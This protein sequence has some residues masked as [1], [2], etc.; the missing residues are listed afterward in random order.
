MQRHRGQ[1]SISGVF[2]YHCPPYFL[3]Q[4]L[5]LSLELTSWLTAVPPVSPTPVNETMAVHH[6]AQFV[7]VGAGLQAFS[8]PSLHL[9]VEPLP[10]PFEGGIPLVLVSTPLQR[11]F[12]LSLHW[13][14]LEVRSADTEHVNI[15]VPPPTLSHC[16][17]SSYPERINPHPVS[18]HKFIV[19]NR[20][21]TSQFFQN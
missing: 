18:L 17:S 20:G 15:P 2:L 1:R 12:L 5:L 3:R 11:T 9:T 21:C 19:E 6:C 8:S 4:D 13:Q 10:S 7:H 16:S 14:P